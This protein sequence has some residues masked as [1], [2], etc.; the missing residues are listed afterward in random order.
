M[1]GN[2]QISDPDTRMT[3]NFVRN[4]TVGFDNK[5]FDMINHINR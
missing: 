4:E 1:D 5:P 2:H 3:L